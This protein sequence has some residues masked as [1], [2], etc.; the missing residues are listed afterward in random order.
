[1]LS[2][3]SSTALTIPAMPSSTLISARQRLRKTLSVS[4]ACASVLRMGMHALAR[5]SILFV[6]SFI[7]EKSVV[8][9]IR[10]YSLTYSGGW[11]ETSQWK[12]GHEA[13]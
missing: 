10:I 1:M 4:A 6:H 11:C 5:Q 3:S 12:S 2:P 8:L 7:L 13:L 9:P